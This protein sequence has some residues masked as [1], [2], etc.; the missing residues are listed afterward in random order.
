MRCTI[1]AAII[2]KALLSNSVSALSHYPYIVPS[3]AL[4][5]VNAN[6]ATTTS[7]SLSCS[8]PDPWPFKCG[9]IGNLTR[10]TQDDTPTPVDSLNDCR[11]LCITN[12]TCSAFGYDKL[13]S[14]CMVLVK[15]L[16]A[17]GLSANANASTTYW[18]R[19]CFSCN[20]LG[21][22]FSTYGINPSCHPHLC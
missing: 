4:H 6:G 17:N 13:G 15:S 10:L 7:P 2:A 3:S 5:R 9:I 14:S 16:K 22:L 1:V 11:D 20:T 21:M 12:H 18:H 8:T 19:N